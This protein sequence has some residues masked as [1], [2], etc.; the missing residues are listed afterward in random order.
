MKN[1]LLSNSTFTKA[2]DNRDI[3][4]YNHWVDSQL[5]RLEEVLKKWFSRNKRATGL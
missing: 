2:G 3:A 5:Y 1:T 4:K